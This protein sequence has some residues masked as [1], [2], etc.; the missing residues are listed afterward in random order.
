MR[1]AVFATVGPRG[2][3]AG[4]MRLLEHEL[5][6]AGHDVE[7][8]DLADVVIDE[9]GTALHRRD[10][11]TGELHPWQPPHAALMYHGAIAPPG[12]MRVLD[13]LERHGTSVVNGA[14]AWP[15]FADKLRFAEYMQAL[16]VRVIPTQL[17]QSAGELD[18]I[19]TRLGGTAVLKKPVSTEGADVFVVRD[20]AALHQV[21]ERL[22]QLGGAV[23][24]QPL[25]DSRLDTRVEPGVRG[26]L[27]PGELGRRHEFRINTV[28]HH[29]DSISVDACYMRV[30]PD[31]EQVVNN[32]AQG[33]RAIVV[34]F[35]ALD[36]ADRATVLEAARCAPETGDVVGWDLIGQPG[37]RRLIEGNSGSGLP[38]GSE[39]VD[40]REVVRSYVRLLTDR[41]RAA[42]AHG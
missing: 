1:T 25:V 31:A 19:V 40:P 8:L 26:Q 7:L 30:S 3:D 10:A 34:E 6:A 21:A 17:A 16:G 11:V 38:K 18:A 22:P 13:V 23:V 42:R 24:V 39:G 41:G 9:D 14:R 35:E 2:A 33:A 12:A 27:L 32:V 28:R 5:R 20:D 36:P 37:E 15:V 29:D 4:D